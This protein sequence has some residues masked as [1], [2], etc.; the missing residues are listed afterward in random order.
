MRVPQDDHSPTIARWPYL[1]LASEPIFNTEFR[2]EEGDPMRSMNRIA[3]VRVVICFLAGVTMGQEGESETSGAARTMRPIVR[4]RHF[5]LA[6]MKAEATLAAER[7]LEKRRNAL[8]AIVAGQ[9][10]LGI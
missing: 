4:G 7:I 2:R 8:D 3:L 5:A 1:A 9:A 10:T 6:A